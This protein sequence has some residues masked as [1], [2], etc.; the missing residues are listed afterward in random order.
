MNKH[1][2]A[3]IGVVI[4][5]ALILASGAFAKKRQSASRLTMD[6]DFAALAAQVNLSEIRMADLAMTKT[7]NPQVKNMA[8]RLEAD[9]MKANDRLKE[10]AAKQNL[11]LPAKLDAKNQAA[12]DRLSKLSG[13]EFDKAYVREEAKDHKSAIA[14]FRREASHGTNPELKKYASET[15]PELEHHL[16]LAEATEPSARREK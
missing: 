14:E 11:T 8:Q 3:V 7:S 13:A 15:L 2:N 16:Q 6:R 5:G 12:Y 9:H 4:S 1:R 10:I